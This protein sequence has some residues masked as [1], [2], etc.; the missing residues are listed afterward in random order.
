MLKLFGTYRESNY[1]HLI[2]CRTMRQPY[3]TTEP[4]VYAEVDSV[5][6]SNKAHL[7]RCLRLD[8]RVPTRSIADL[9]I[10][11]RV[12]PALTFRLPLLPHWPGS[13]R[14]FRLIV[15]CRRRLRTVPELLRQIPIRFHA[16]TVADS[17]CVLEAK[18]KRWR[19]LDLRVTSQSKSV[20][21]RAATCPLRRSK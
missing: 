18:R 4:S 3:G 14:R 10:H 6:T 9:M 1:W 12:V 21:V 11:L 20:R 17:A 19:H 2:I 7:P 16:T 15:K 5:W 8:P 13:C